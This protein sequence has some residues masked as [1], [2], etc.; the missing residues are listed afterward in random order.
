MYINSQKYIKSPLNYIGGKFKL[1]KYIIPLFPKN[2]NTF[3]DLFA[4]GCNVGINAPAK[5]VIFN[6][7]LVYLIDIYKVFKNKTINEILSF[8]NQ[9]IIEFDL[10]D[11]NEAGYKSLRS[12]YNLNKNPLD[13]FILTAY[14][15]N[16]QIR[17]NN[18][19]EY[20][21]PFG[22]H[23]S[24][25]NENM[26]ANLINFIN[27]IKLLNCDFTDLNF[28][29]FDFSKIG[30]EDF[31]YCDP[32]YLITNGTYNDGK[33]GFTGWGISEEK[34]LIN[35]L[36]SLN[37]R[38]IRFALS[39]VI[40]HNEVTNELLIEWIK[41]TPNLKLRVIDGDYTNSNYQ[42]RNRDKTTTKEILV[43]NYDTFVTENSVRQEFI[44]SM[45]I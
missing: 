15:F 43:V 45:L 10:S 11:E 1:L 9:R 32:P 22:R 26:K 19:H 25:F 38:N 7:N 33:R 18:L 28:D 35:L 29:K 12:E 34:K 14:S 42:K 5:K 16:H 39:N 13:L 6:D 23:K 44:E 30:I 36:D 17:F 27:K 41:N 31:V 8:I 24:R 2:I 4:G 21:N 20:N 40:E 37:N 3:I